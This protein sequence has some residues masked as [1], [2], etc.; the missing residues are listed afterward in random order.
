MKKKLIFI[1]IIAIVALIC[2]TMI[3]CQEPESTSVIPVTF[4]SVTA[5]GNKTQSTTVLTMTFSQAISG[6][7]ANDITLSGVSDVQKGNL[8]GFGVTYT[9]PI[10][11]FTSGGTLSVA[12]VKSGYN[13]SGSPKKATIYYPSVTFTNVTANG[14][15]TQTTTALTM[16]FSQ[17]INGLTANDITLSGVSD[18]QKG[19]LS[20]FGVTYTLPISGFTSGGTLSVAVVKSGYAISDSPKT[21]DIYYT[22]P[23]VGIVI[24]LAGINDWELI[25]QTVQTTPGGYKYFTVTGTYESYRWYLDGVL[26]GIS[27][28]YIFNKPAG[29]Y[30][31]TV[32]V[33]NSNGESRSGRC[34]ITV[35]N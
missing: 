24:D 16:T 34:R 6:L 1:G 14:N 27:S 12:V 5:N 33:T 18:V 29:M 23:T 26:V 19:N 28:G 7:T 10:S 21:V 13:I 25:E 30:Q 9:L 8:S 35:G 3:A 15:E 32:V 31:L 4:N 11:G 2:F 22:P 20:G 17:A